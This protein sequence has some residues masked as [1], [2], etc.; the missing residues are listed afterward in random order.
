MKAA[1]ENILEKLRSEKLVA[2]VVKIQAFFRMSHAKL[3]YKKIRKSVLLL[4][5]LSRTYVARSFFKKQRKRIVKIQACMNDNL[6]LI[7]GSVSWKKS[8]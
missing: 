1:T 3:R 7:L 8:A 5:R 6:S 2:R 4:Q